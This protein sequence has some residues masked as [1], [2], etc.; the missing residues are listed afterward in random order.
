MTPSSEN[1]EVP[2]YLS[3]ILVTP[4]T[5]HVSNLSSCEGKN[6]PFQSSMKHHD[7]VS[8][9]KDFPVR[10]NVAFPIKRNCFKI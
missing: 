7:D 3:K 6:P 4:K 8:N 10:L 1:H 5:S 9:Q 2:P